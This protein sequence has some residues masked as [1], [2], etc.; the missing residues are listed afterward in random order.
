M[1]SWAL[2]VF[3]TRAVEP[4]MTLFKALVIPHLEYCCQLWSPHLLKDIRRLE[5][6]Q[7]SFTARIAGMDQLTYWERLEHLKLYSLERRRERYIILYTYKIIQNLVPNFRDDRFTINTYSS[8][9]GNRLCR[10][11]SISR[12]SRA[13]IR[14]L[15][16]HSF[17][18]RG[19]KLFNCLP[20]E[21]RN[22]QGSFLTFKFKLDKLLSQV[23]DQPCTPGYHQPA[24]SNSIIAQLAQMR[25]DGLYL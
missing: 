21:I 14:N 5:A 1:S 2:R 10:V 6:I 20:A 23:I 17:A 15:V 16:E 22:F 13:K 9:R 24:V 12:A 4:M 11:P 8:V 18:I 7:R 25:A 19:P 3:K